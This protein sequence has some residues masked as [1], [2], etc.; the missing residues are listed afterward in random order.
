LKILRH[1][2]QE[3]FFTY[4]IRFQ[5]ILLKSFHYSTFN[6]WN[7][8]FFQ[9]KRGWPKSNFEHF[10]IFFLEIN[11]NFSI[12]ILCIVIPPCYF[13]PVIYCNYW[14]KWIFPST[15]SFNWS[16]ISYFTIQSVGNFTLYK[17]RFPYLCCRF[18]LIIFKWY[19]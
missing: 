9:K 18:E 3:Y 6:F 11:I 17:S 4:Y 19:M 15:P 13:F 14:Q 7:I 5:N 16:K 8:K 1:F 12:V 10:H 2:Y